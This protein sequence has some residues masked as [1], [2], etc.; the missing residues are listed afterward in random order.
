ML[1]L[2]TQTPPPFCANRGSMPVTQV[3]VSTAHLVCC[4]VCNA[5]NRWYGVHKLHAQM[6]LQVPTNYPDLSPNPMSR[7]FHAVTDEFRVGFK[8]KATSN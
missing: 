4:H 5:E 1:M 3:E 2:F 8:R 6:L 7:Q